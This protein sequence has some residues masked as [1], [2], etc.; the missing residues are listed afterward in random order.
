MSIAT[1]YFDKAYDFQYLKINKFKNFKDSVFRTCLI[2]YARHVSSGASFKTMLDDVIQRIGYSISFKTFSRYIDRLTDIFLVEDLPAWNLNYRS[3]TS[4][5]TSPVRHF[6]DPSFACNALGLT[7]KNMLNDVKTLGLVF[8][9]MAIRDLRIYVEKNGG[10]IKHYRE[11][12]GLECDSVI[13]FE[14]GRI[15]LVELKLGGFEACEK[16]AHNL[17]KIQ[18]NWFHQIIILLLFQWS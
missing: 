2:S 11:K 13:T 18:K 4:M 3:K 1:D 7:P 6:I 17:L 5:R 14:D 9:D 10:N 12:N 8:E 16:A 15:A